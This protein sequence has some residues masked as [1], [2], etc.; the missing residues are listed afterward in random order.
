MWEQGSISSVLLY[1]VCSLEPNT[2]IKNKLIPPNTI[3][4]LNIINESPELVESYS[5]LLENSD[6]SLIS[7]VR[8]NLIFDKVDSK[9]RIK[10]SILNNK[11][12][13]KNK[14]TR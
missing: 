9:F 12:D 6:S 8:I 13:K 2:D 3:D 11:I 7:A 5:F 4:T 1:S 14:K 10:N